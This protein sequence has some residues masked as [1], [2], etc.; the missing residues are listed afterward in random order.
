MPILLL[1]PRGPAAAAALEA[2]GVAA[3]TEVVADPLEGL[4][5]LET[6]GW[7]LV[8]LDAALAGGAALD[9]VEPLSVAGQPVVVLMDRPTLAATVRVLRSGA[10]DVLTFPPSP[11]RLRQVTEDLAGASAPVVEAGVIGSGWIGES[12]ALLG[13]FRMAVRM[14][15]AETPILIAGESGTGKESL[16][17]VIHAASPR[18]EGPFVSVNCGALSE[19]VLQSELFG[20]ERGAFAGAYGRRLGRFLKASGGTLL[21]DELSRLSPRLQSSVARVLRERVIEP[22]GAPSAEPVDTRVIAAVDSQVLAG[23]GETGL[24]PELLSEFGG[25]VL[26]LPPLRERGEVDIRLLTS[27]FVAEFAQRYNRRMRGVAQDAWSVLVR[28]PWPGNVRQL[29]GVIERAVVEAEGDVIH[30]M[31]LPREIR[32]TGER[33]PAEGSLLLDDLEKR[34][35][36]SV[37]EMTG[38]HLGQTADLLGIHRNTLRRKLQGYGI[39]AD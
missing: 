30:A 3:R 17:R 15:A 20:H 31:H 35:I 24:L 4:R 16:A 34:H 28:H 25:A 6:E 38:G 18:S 22:L 29:R 33:M 12:P 27:H 2:A 19:S 1:S 9:L 36:L 26:H 21:L 11:E 5:R 23:G 37:L 32:R 7:E 8:L 39:E 10:R 13:A 14:A